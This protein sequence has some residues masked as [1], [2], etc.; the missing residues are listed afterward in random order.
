MRCSAR[1]RA[2]C[3]PR[4]TSSVPKSPRL[5]ASAI[6]VSSRSWS[7]SA[8]S[9]PATRP[10]SSG[11]AGGSGCSTSPRGHA[12][13]GG[14]Q[15]R[16]VARGEAGQQDGAREAA[17]EA[18]DDGRAV[19]RQHPRGGEEAQLREEA[20]EHGRAQPV[21]G[22]VVGRRG[23]R[24]SRERPSGGLVGPGRRDA[25]GGGL[26]GV[27]VGRRLGGLAGV[28]RGRG[29]GSACGSR[30]GARPA[31]ACSAGASAR[32]SAAS[33]RAAARLR[34]PRRRA[35]ACSAASAASGLGRLGGL[36]LG[37]GRG[38]LLVDRPGQDRLARARASWSCCGRR[39][40]GAARPARGRCSSSA[41]RSRIITPRSGCVTSRPRNM[42][43]IL[44][45][46]LWRRKRSTWP[47]LVA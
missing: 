44:T 33:R 39:G 29:R 35:S 40:S 13:G 20:G 23:P 7:C 28:L 2:S 30:R 42:I 38:L 15:V 22:P 26:G 11:P 47:F 24:L 46:S 18:A 9:A 10:S 32:R 5:M 6:P 4:S 31:A 25:L 12:A 45:L 21:H 3:S 43:V 1:P 27:V 17:D 19:A 34:R 36:R 14:A 41:R 37:G 16:G 8:R